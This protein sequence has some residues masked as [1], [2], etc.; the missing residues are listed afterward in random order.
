MDDDLVPGA[1]VTDYLE[2]HMP[3]RSNSQT[4]DLFQAEYHA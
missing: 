1:I 3:N 4:N 2:I